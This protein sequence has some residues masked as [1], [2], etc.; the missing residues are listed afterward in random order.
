MELPWDGPNERSWFVF[1]IRLAEG[2]DRAGVIEQMAAR[3]IATRPYL[4]AIHLQPPYRERYGYGPGLL[5]VTERVSISSLALPFFVDLPD[6]DV[7]YV[8]ESLAEVLAE[9]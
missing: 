8:V 9:T 6:E 5:P 3:G 2:I 7:D 1:Y 4:P